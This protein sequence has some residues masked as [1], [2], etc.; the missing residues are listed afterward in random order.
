M[1]FNYL[2][3]IFLI[4]TI[5]CQK[6][7]KS[8]TQI[9]IPRGIPAKPQ[10]GPGN[11]PGGTPTV[12]QKKMPSIVVNRV[13]KSSMA[14][15]GDTNF[16]LE[17]KVEGKIKQNY[18]RNKILNFTTKKNSG[19]DITLPEEINPL[20]EYVVRVSNWDS[21]HYYRFYQRFFREYQPG[22]W[23]GQA[24]SNFDL[25]LNGFE[26]TDRVQDIKFSLL[27]HNLEMG[28]L[29]EINRSHLF[30]FRNQEV[31]FDGVPEQHYITPN[32]YKFSLGSLKTGTIEEAFKQ[33]GDLFIKLE[34]FS[35]GQKGEGLQDFKK[36]YTALSRRMTKVVLSQASSTSV[37][38]VKPG[39]KLIDIVKGLDKDVI[40]SE[41]Q[42]LVEFLGS[43]TNFFEPIASVNQNTAIE[44]F[45][46]SLWLASSSKKKEL[47]SDS[48]L[49][50]G[51]IL[52][53]AFATVQKFIYSKK[54][55]KMRFEMPTFVNSL[56]FDQSDP[57]DMI[58]VFGEAE[59][60]V[61]SNAA[62]QVQTYTAHY[63][64][65]VCRG[66]GGRGD[67]DPLCRMVTRTGACGVL[68]RILGA[69]EFSPLKFEND[70]SNFRLFLKIGEKTWQPKEFLESFQ[71]FDND[72]KFVFR[73]RL[74]R[75]YFPNGKVE[76]GFYI[77][78]DSHPMS[79]N[80]GYVQDADCAI[81]RHR[82][83]RFSNYSQQP[84]AVTVSKK[85]R[86][87]LSLREL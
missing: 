25:S 21:L 65:E 87:K 38:F 50:D 18:F 35:Y 5:S 13:F 59:Q 86:F 22:V 80:I 20:D 28:V 55:K 30:E 11:N 67:R 31:V 54:K 51:E 52:V 75:E 24:E 79:I 43:R 56:N 62:T 85:Q 82:N 2:L 77:A 14:L 41:D 44:D 73:F 60:G 3:L 45:K 16:V 63:D 57:G 40:F 84:K 69:V 64:E 70:L 46:K 81:R 58:E 19:F 4:V 47:N 78:E 72:Q 71:L 29:T 83:F 23:Q 17:E 66:G 15:I 68:E 7:N 1:R 76:A 27:T 37:F 10:V 39:Q 42:M 48:V 6:K 12:P 53:L 49:L 8:K 34:N 74:K 33:R 9:L 36:E 32:R 26:K 61:P